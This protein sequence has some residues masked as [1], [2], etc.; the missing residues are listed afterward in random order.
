MKLLKYIWIIGLLFTIS[1]CDED[2]LIEKPL[3][4]LS[5]NNSFTKP[6]DIDAALTH[7]Y[8]RIR[9]YNDGKYWTTSYLHYGTDLAMDP[10]SKTDKFGDYPTTLLPTTARANAFWTKYYHMI[11]NSNVVLTRIGEIEYQDETEKAVHVAEAKF[12]RGYAYRC[13]VHLYGGV[14]LVEE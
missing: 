5:P 13:L 14:P 4:F 9:S 12:F 8:N 1:S 6:G 2:L 3:D 11:F 7:Q 10:R